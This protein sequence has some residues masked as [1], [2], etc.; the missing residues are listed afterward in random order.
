MEKFYYLKYLD[1]K[2]WKTKILMQNPLKS[3]T[4]FDSLWEYMHFGNFTD[5]KR[6]SATYRII[7]SGVKP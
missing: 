4:F 1:W 2:K 3:W 5:M 7:K 6:I